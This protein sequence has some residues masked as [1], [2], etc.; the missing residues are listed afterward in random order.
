[1][2]KKLPA[3]DARQVMRRSDYEIAHKLD[4]YLMDV[5]LHHHDF[6]EIY[7]LL[8]G[9]VT[10]FIE[11]RIYNVRP[12]DVLLISTNELHHAVIRPDTAPYERYVLW[13]DPVLLSNLSTSK[14]NLAKCF[15]KNGSRHH[16]LLHLSHF[17]RSTVHA[18]MELI[19]QESDTQTAK[20]NYGSDLF[21]NS[22]L[23]SLLVLL[24]RAATDATDTEDE[25]ESVTQG[26]VTEVVNY[27]NL[28]YSDTITLDQLSEQ[29]FVSKFHLSHEFSK[30]VGTSIYRY[31][32]KKRLQIA[33]QLLRQGVRSNQACISCG[34]GDYVGFYRAFRA[35]YGISPREYVMTLKRGQH[36][37]LP[38]ARKQM[39]H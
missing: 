13:V 39:P 36:M 31:L 12:G 17:Q 5:E 6:L 15:D 34:F 27:L 16:N 2:E 20:E 38:T 19:Y 4:N 23:T 3:Y 8:S 29:L 35:E 21:E 11:S 18:W 7:F 32:Q 25:K 9:D 14:T 1:M 10:Y 22:L 24:N 28:H 26:L 30:Q 33:C 37:D